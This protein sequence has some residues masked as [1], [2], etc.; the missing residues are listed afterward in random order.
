M[1]LTD[2][3]ITASDIT[4][5]GVQSQPDR[6]TGTA[7]ENKAVFDKLIEEILAVK[8][9][10]LIDELAAAIAGKMAAPDTE[11]SAGQYLQTD[12]EGG[13]TWATPSGAG[14]MLRS[15]YDSDNDGIVESADY[16]ELAERA[17]RLST[18]RSIQIQDAT[19]TNTGVSVSFDGSGNIVLKLPAAIAAAITGDV[20]GNAATATKLKTARS[21]GNASFD[22]STAVTL[23]EMG[24]LPAAGGTVTGN[25]TLSAG[26]LMV[27]GE[28]YGETLPAT[29]LTAG[30]LF[31][32]KV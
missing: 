8:L 20:T 16:A 23:A 13:R 10:A 31:F 5:N 28:I 25:L 27:N 4:E 19:G 18:P 15:T 17:T 12:G 21:I 6:L 11:G 14:D 1:A 30:R 22:G 32:K 29:N 7:A 3:K 2:Y 9:N 24:A 26:R